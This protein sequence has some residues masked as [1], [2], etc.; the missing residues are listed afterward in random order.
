[1]IRSYVR[2]ID[3]TRLLGTLEEEKSVLDPIPFCP[4]IGDSI[5]FRAVFRLPI[6]C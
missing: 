1:M 6:I 4:V 3:A 5:C 2:L